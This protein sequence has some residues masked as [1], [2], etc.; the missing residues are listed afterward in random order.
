MINVYQQITLSEAA[1]SNAICLSQAGTGGSPLLLNGASVSG[2]E[3]VLSE[4]RRVLISSSGDNSG[5]TFR[6]YGQNRYG[7]VSEDIIGPNN[8]SVYT[9]ND[10]KTI[11]SI[12]PLSST[13]GNVTVGTNGVASGEWVIL[14]P[15]EVPTQVSIFCTLSQGA[16]LTYTVEYTNYE[17]MNTYL[18]DNNRIINNDPSKYM[19][20]PATE[21][22]PYPFENLVNA[23]AKSSGNYAFPVIATR[24]VLNTYSSGTLN[25]NVLQTS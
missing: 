3:A 20:V 18:F 16:S 8:G 23:T 4:N 12:T 9:V 15:K 24:V 21:I 19:N 1:S 25:F 14:N 22:F 11:Q 13:V 6:I 10:F 2:G 7:L 17:L 5:V